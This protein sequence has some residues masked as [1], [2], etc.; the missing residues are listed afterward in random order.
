MSIL[1][2][3]NRLSNTRKIKIPSVKAHFPNPKER[4]Y[5][6][7]YITRY[8]AQRNKGDRH[9]IYEISSNSYSTLKSSIYYKVGS[10]KW[11]IS[12]PKEAIYD[13]SGFLIDKGVIASNRKS[14]LLEKETLPD[15]KYHLQNLTQFYK[16]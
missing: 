3:Y 12:G 5:E 7:G 1:K 11:R 9:P 6:K 10:V 14:I 13:E 2:S 8:F 4:D 15:L 16:K